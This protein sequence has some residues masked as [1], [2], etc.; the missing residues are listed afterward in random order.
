MQLCCLPSMPKTLTAFTPAEAP[1]S[2]SAG[3]EPVAC[4]IPA[5]DSCCASSA[6]GQTKDFSKKTAQQKHVCFCTCLDTGEWMVMYCCE[7]EG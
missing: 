4:G 7:L 1:A 6:R 2:S 5:V 3:A